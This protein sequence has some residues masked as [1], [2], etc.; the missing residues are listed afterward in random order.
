MKQQTFGE[1]KHRQKPRILQFVGIL[2]LFYSL[3]APGNLLAVGWGV[4]RGRADEGD[5]ATLLVD[6]VA[7]K[8]ARNRMDQA[9]VRDTLAERKAGLLAA[10]GFSDRFDNVH[11]WW[12]E[13]V[14]G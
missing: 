7:M 4:E 13:H 11:D 10:P 9:L 14:M 12:L 1:K 8:M 5:V 6:Q 3:A 2:A